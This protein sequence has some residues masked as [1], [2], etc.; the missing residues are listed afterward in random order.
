V[1]LPVLVAAALAGA[2]ATE[3]ASATAPI[4]AAGQD[5]LDV[6]ITLK[7]KDA[8]V[9]DLLEKFADLLG[10]TPILDPGVG[11]R[12][13]VEIENVPARKALEMVGQAAK[14][15]VTVSARVLRARPKAG[16]DAAGPATAP[17]APRVDSSP[18]GG[19]LRFWRDGMGEPAVAVRV[20]DSVGRVELSACA[21]PVTLGRLG[22]VGGATVGVALATADPSGGGARGRILG[23]SAASGTKVLLAGCDGRLVVEVGD[24]LPGAA[25]I[26]PVRP[27]KGEPV[28]LTM[29]LLEVTE[30]SEES[31][32]EP[33]VAFRSD[34]GFSVKSGFD[35]GPKDAFGQVAEIHGVPLDLRAEEGSLLLA[36]R[37]AVTRTPAGG[38]PVLA[39]R[40]A[41]TFRLQK[42]KPLRWTVDSSWDGG[43]AAI[44]LELTLER[45]GAAPR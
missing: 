44:A 39:A 16:A 28:V 19:V 25:V 43:R 20:P 14:V 45:I 35:A 29:R 2:P 7:L 40:R 36:V 30:S 13:S 21:G 5:R 22:A 15:D 11:G 12:V 31:V 17:A 37:A 24:P 27:P 42:G 4:E 34:A 23:E 8:S 18:L 6:P 41:E 9:V 1:I 26:E 38:G 3:A 33:K 32:S 10:V